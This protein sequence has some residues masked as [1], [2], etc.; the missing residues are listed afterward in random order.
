MTA[1]SLAWWV[2]LV[3]S[4]TMAL[5]V[6]CTTNPTIDG[7]SVAKVGGP[8]APPACKDLCARLVKLCGFAPKECT[9]PDAT[10]YCDQYWDDANRICRGQAATCQAAG[11]CT[12][13]SA[14]ASASD[15]ETDAEGDASNED[16]GSDANA[17]AKS[18]DAKAD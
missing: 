14:D 17:D 8:G 13:A 5:G 18:G 6:A 11:D 10:G 1:R 12:N 9:L 15:A 4:G 3:V 16:G 2:T 7:A